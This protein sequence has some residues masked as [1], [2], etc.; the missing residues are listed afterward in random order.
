[1][2]EFS[3]ELDSKEFFDDLHFTNSPSVS[4][5]NSTELLEHK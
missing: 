5:L 1:V 2:S 3:R 4:P